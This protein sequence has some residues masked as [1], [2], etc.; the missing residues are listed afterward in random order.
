MARGQERTV[1]GGEVSPYVQQ[2]LLQGKEQA[3]NRLVAAMNNAGAAQRQEQATQ[4]QSVQQG[5]QLGAEAYQ[6]AAQRAQQEKIAANRLAGEREDRILRETEGNAN[7]ALQERLAQNELDARQADS[8][9]DRGLRQKAM[10]Q[11]WATSKAQ[12]KMMGRQSLLS[13]N[14][15]ITTMKLKFGDQQSKEK[16]AGTLLDEAETARK[17]NELYNLEQINIPMRL[18]KDKRLDKPPRVEYRE[19]ARRGIY[20]FGIHYEREPIVGSQTD[21]MGI[22]QDAVKDAGSKINILELTPERYRDLEQCVVGGKYDAEDFSAARAAIDALIP[23]YQ[24]KADE[25]SETLW[26]K[27][28]KEEHSD[29]IYWEDQVYKLQTMKLQFSKLINSDLPLK[30]NPK[31]TVGKMTRLGLGAI[32]NISFGSSVRNF[33][34]Q[35]MNAGQIIDEF[36]KSQDPFTPM[37]LAEGANEFDIEIN[38]IINDTYSKGRDMVAKTRQTPPV[39]QKTTPNTGNNW[40]AY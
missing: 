9:A 3:N 39:A 14:A 18:K 28:D 27:G 1:T 19:V 40:G 23:I 32:D 12:L 29:K 10:D 20:E 33:F 31:M 25:A 26:D 5:A 6:A 24:G 8:Q 11:A 30:S 13:Y 37:E 15:L 21:P 17:N 4:A 34:D 22:T 16:L 35:G 2:S 7:R 36:T 38:N